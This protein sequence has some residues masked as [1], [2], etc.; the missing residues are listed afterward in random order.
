MPGTRGTGCAG[1]SPPL[2]PQ[3]K[4]E[5]DAERSITQSEVNNRHTREVALLGLP[6]WGLTACLPEA[7]PSVHPHPTTLHPRADP[8][9]PVLLPRSPVHQRL[10]RFLKLLGSAASRRTPGT[11]PP[12]TPGLLPQE[13]PSA[14]LPL[15]SLPQTCAAP[16]SSGV[17]PLPSPPPFPPSWALC[18]AGLT[19]PEGPPPPCPEAS[20]LTPVSQD[21]PREMAQVMRSLRSHCLWGPRSSSKVQPPLYP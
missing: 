11:P 21:H 20:L 5:T 10:V 12:W 3:Q 2:I 13:S 18:R 17:G 14:T 19:A 16:A 8:A 1:G 9:P 15:L 4:T 6:T 7:L